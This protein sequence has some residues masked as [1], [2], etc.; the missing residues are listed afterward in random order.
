MAQKKK[1]FYLVDPL[2]YT[3]LEKT[4]QALIDSC[5]VVYHNTSVDSI[6]LNC[7]GK[8]SENL[9][10][11]ELS[12]KY[13]LLFLTLAEK[14]QKEKKYERWL[15]ASWNTHAYFL[16]ELDG[17]VPG[18][19]D[20]YQRS[21]RLYRSMRSSEG[22][23]T[24][25]TNL[26]IVYQQQGNNEAALKFNQE[27]Y[28]N[29]QKIKD[30]E[31]AGFALN[32]MGQIYQAIGNL[33]KALELYHSSLKIAE[34][35][36]DPETI[37]TTL[38]SIAAVYNALT[39]YETAR[40]YFFRAY[41]EIKKTG[42]VKT[43]GIALNN[44]GS[45]YL[46]M[47]SQDSASHF[48][49]RALET[50]DASPAFGGKAVALSN[51]GQICFL[52]KKY[53]DAINYYNRAFLIRQEIN[54]VRGLAYSNMNLGEVYF[55]MG[56][57]RKAEEFARRSLE[58]SQ[59]HGYPANIRLSAE[60]LKKIFRMKKE[61]KHALEMDELFARMSDSIMSDENRRASVKKQFQY[62]YEK[63]AAA[64]SVKVT[65][66][67]KISAVELQQEQTQR[68]AL[69]GGLVAVLLFS[70][71]VYR[72]FRISQQQKN[73]IERQK[74]LVEEKQKEILDSIHYA[75]RIQRAL[76]TNEKYIDRNLRKLKK[77]V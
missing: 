67:K 68:Y 42:D 41:R 61:Y 8:L 53:T 5:L 35:D 26:A 28:L 44:I 75:H 24:T 14:H 29:Y 20:Y 25:C 50:L 30:R 70:L 56:N 72:R 39:E 58:L 69:Y 3:C 64:D 49:S 45:N 33:Q 77:N 65:E 47:G 32:N 4:D 10:D 73:I 37:G 16:Q 2:C 11:K 19:I 52:R 6:K 13:A 1:E 74:H 40:S 7:L 17:D 71:I 48:F 43:L 21:L 38:T 59:K 76:I 12:A 34:D 51:L 60:L 57:T 15:A 9:E 31:G 66:Q 63:K 55:E 46:K 27:A 36:G 54:D 22:M 18:A 62:E 23:A